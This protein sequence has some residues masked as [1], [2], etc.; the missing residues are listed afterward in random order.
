MLLPSPCGHKECSILPSMKP[1]IIARY[2][3][4]D[5]KTLE[6][7][8]LAATICFPT[9]IKVCYS[10]EE[11][12]EM[13]DD[14]L[15]SLT[16]QKG[17]RYYMMTYHFYQK[18]NNSEY[19]ANYEMHPLKNHLMKFGD[20]YLALSDEGFT[21]KII[22][23]VQETLEL[24]QELG[25]RDYVYVPFCICLISKYPYAYEMTRCLQSIFNVMSEE[26]I[27]G[28][29]KTDFKINDLIMYLI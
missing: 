2:P 21:E 15:T 19:T 9:G 8:N 28:F 12:T 4:E 26:E 25:F 18:I 1:E 24:C 6:L 14:Y 22:K 11:P 5:T 27:M 10:E 23:K 29:V 7:N 20:S 13:I 17:E 3:L 16:N